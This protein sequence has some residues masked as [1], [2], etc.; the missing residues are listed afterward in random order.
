MKGELITIKPDGAI[1]RK[2]ITAPPE[3]SELQTAVGGYIEKVPMFDTFEKKTCV[4]LCNEE[5]KLKRLPVNE[6]A[7]FLW[8]EQNGGMI[9]DCL[10][11][12]V[13]LI[14]GYKKLMEAL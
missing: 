7:T 4:A 13:V 9:S 2:P 10:V 11:G 14:R 3:L 5:G 1:E 8:H 12:T 6:E